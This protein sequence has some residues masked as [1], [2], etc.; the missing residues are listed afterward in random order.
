MIFKKSDEKKSDFFAFFRCFE[1][2]YV[3]KIFK[4]FHTNMKNKKLLFRFMLMAF[5]SLCFSMSFWSALNFH[6]N[7]EGI[8]VLTQDSIFDNMMYVH[9]A[10][11]WNNFWWFLYFSNGI[12]SMGSGDELFE[13]GTDGTESAYEC[14]SQVKGFYYNAERWERLRPLDQDTWSG[15]LKNAWLDTTWWIYTNCSMA[16][17]RAALEECANNEEEVYDDC[18]EQ[19]RED[20][21]A[22][23][24]GYYWYLSHT[25]SWQELKLIMWVEYS[26]NRQFISIKSGSKLSSTFVRLNNKYPV[27]F[28]Y[29]Y[30]WWVGLAWCRFD[31]NLTGGSMKRLIAEAQATGLSNI[32]EYNWERFTLE[33]VGN[34]I[35]TWIKCD[36]VSAADSLVKIIVEWIMWLDSSGTWNAKFGAMG[37]STDT[38]MQY[39]ATKSV[40]NITMINYA[41]RKAESLCRGKW[42]D[43]PPSTSSSENIICLNIA[44]DLIID[45]DNYDKKTLIVKWWANVKVT[46][47]KDKIYDIFVEW[48]DLLVNE[49]TGT[50]KVVIKSNGFISSTPYTGFD[51]FVM[52]T[53][54]DYFGANISTITDVILRKNDQWADA[55]QKLYYPEFDFAWSSPY[56]DE[57]GNQIPIRDIDDVNAVIECICRFD[58]YCDPE[59][60]PYNHGCML[61]DDVAAASVIKWNFIVDGHIRNANTNDGK[62]ANKYFVYGKLTTRDDLSSLEDT[63]SWRCEAWIA[64]NLDFCPGWKNHPTPYQ[65]AALVVI[66]QNYNSPLL[67][68]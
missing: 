26:W 64:N 25:Y 4:L 38:K 62:L 58:N 34:A 65:N 29:D 36:A 15:V 48:W 61:W 17:Y 51:S 45:A 22:D 46:P 57:A 39:F 52:H 56:V 32:F 5:V 35:I 40:S 67:R 59:V 63:F 60:D 55:Q 44:P 49:S 68:S 14:S 28:I 8:R 2:N 11:N 47:D 20:F 50:Q 37:N 10:D 42:T 27:G 33:Y 24:Y 6:L 41:R 54:V 13:I 18:A 66:D 43:T 12:T 53:M 21:Y 1:Y 7:L 9:F 16:W 3:K 23:G 30:N 19:V 31:S